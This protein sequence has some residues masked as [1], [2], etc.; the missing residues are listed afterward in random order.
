MN[1]YPVTNCHFCN[2]IMLYTRYENGETYVHCNNDT[3]CMG[4]TYSCKKNV[5]VKTFTIS[6]ASG[7]QFRLYL[8]NG[9]TATNSIFTKSD[10]IHNLVKVEPNIILDKEQSVKLLS[11]IRKTVLLLD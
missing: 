7:L 9:I 5:E 3:S 8:E 1:T 2:K 6:D 10:I 4:F 11:K